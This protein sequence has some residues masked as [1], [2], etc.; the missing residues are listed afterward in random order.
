MSPLDS[1]RYHFA[2]LQVGFMAMEP[3][4]GYIRAWVGGIDYDHFQ[5]DH[6]RAQRQTGSVY[7]PIIYAQALRSGIPPCEQLPNRLTVYHEYAKGDWAIKDPRRDD[8]DPHISPE[9]KDEDD[10]VPQNAD[11][12]YGGSY[13]MQ[14]AL[15]NS[16]NTIS[17]SLIM[18][19]GVQPVIELSRRLGITGE[20]PEEPSIA[21]GTAEVS[22][23]DMVGAFGTIASRGRKTKPIVISRIETHDGKILARFDQG[24]P[25][26]ILT[27]TQADM[28]TH[29]LQSVASY[30][31]ASR[32]KWKYGLY[33]YAI[34]GKT[35]TTQNQADGW[36]IGFT[37]NLVAGA[38][39]GGDSPLVR[40]RTFEYG[41]GA[42]TALPVWGVFM[43]KLLED[44]AFAAW[45]EA[46][47]PELPPDISR[48]L[49]CTMRIKSAEE[50]LA[51]SLAADTLLPIDLEF[52]APDS[53][54]TF[55]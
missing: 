15:T 16:V 45:K 52:P 22:L 55:F 40:F 18:R 8:P 53:T 29:M 10:W 7:K 30:G 54:N 37:P 17:V 47:F 21:L 3:Y 23:Y 36:F 41:Q 39:V 2:L 6:V 14:G 43:K 13:S 12:K 20:I 26:Q 27:E 35:G 42:A 25:E 51:D 9:G 34:A 48:E 49:A 46:K 19:T 31:T 4:T 5:Y 28:V 32:L 1:I 44:P 38:W 33:N 24:Q 11:G 50:L